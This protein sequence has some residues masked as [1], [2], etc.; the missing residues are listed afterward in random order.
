MVSDKLLSE[1]VLT[2]IINRYKLSGEEITS[3]FLSHIATKNYE[4]TRIARMKKGGI[5]T[6]FKKIT[7]IAVAGT[8]DPF[9]IGHEALIKAAFKHK[10]SDNVLVGVMSDEYV[11]RTKNRF[12]TPY[13]K[14]VAAVRRYCE[15]IA[16]GKP[17]KISKISTTFGHILIISEI[18]YIVLSTEGDYNEWLSI[19]NESRDTPVIPIIVPVV[20]DEKAE[21]IS[22]TNIRNGYITRYGKYPR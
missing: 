5:T 3:A 1:E 2:A 10:K 12:A 17:F 13:R 16:N 14:R 8:F 20:S 21:R 22:S 4:V 6:S 9:H 15:T 18:K 19:V 11:K 7:S